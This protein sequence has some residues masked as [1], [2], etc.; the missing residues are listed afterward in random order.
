MLNNRIS[1]I[2]VLKILGHSNPS[3]TQDIYGHLYNEMQVEA[4]RLMDK[5][6]S[7]IKIK[8]LD[9]VYSVASRG[10]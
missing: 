7:L 5:Q 4:G 9:N 1:L 3:I 2:V 6:V 10:G 8:L